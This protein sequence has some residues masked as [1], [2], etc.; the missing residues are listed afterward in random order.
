MHFLLLRIKIPLGP[1]LSKGE[2]RKRSLLKCFT[3]I[4]HCKN[5]FPCLSP[6]FDKGGWGGFLHTAKLVRNDITTNL[7]FDFSEPVCQLYRSGQRYS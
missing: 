1:P 5:A 3:F 7:T 2:G 6:P 4:N